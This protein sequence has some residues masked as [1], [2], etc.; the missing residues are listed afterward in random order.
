[1]GSHDFHAY[2]ST[3][4]CRNYDTDFP[5]YGARRKKAGTFLQ[6]QHEGCS[7]LVGSPPNNGTSFKTVTNAKGGIGFDIGFNTAAEASLF[8][9]DFA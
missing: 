1:M 7:V 2:C 3:A 8:E 5:S 9:S 4:G 6:Q